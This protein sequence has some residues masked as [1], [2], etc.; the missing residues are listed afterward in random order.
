MV[1]TVTKLM[2]LLL[3]YREVMFEEDS[4][5]R[6]SCIVNLLVRSLRLYCTN[7]LIYVCLI[8]IIRFKLIVYFPYF[9]RSSA[10]KSTERNC[11]FVIYINCMTFMFSKV[12]SLKQ[13]TLLNSTAANWN[14]VTTKFLQRFE[15][16]QIATLR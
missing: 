11:I 2:D 16:I 14:G 7:L 1:I 12:T 4:A 5:N 3:Q 8:L 15:R 13:H 6:M 9:C 10:K